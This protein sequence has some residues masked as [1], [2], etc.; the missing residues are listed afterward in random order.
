MKINR[1]NIEELLIEVFI[2]CGCQREEATIVAHNLV[3][4]EMCGVASHGLR[5]V[6]AHADKYRSSVYQYAKPL[7]IEV[8]TNAFAKINANGMCGLYSATRCMEFAI[9]KA[10]QCGMYTVFANHCNTYG[11]A[12]VYSLMAA[13]QGLIGITFCNTPAQMAPI[14][15]ARKMLGTNPMSYAIPVKGE[16]PIIYD[17]ATSIVAKSKINVAAERGDEIPIEWALDENGVPTTNAKEAQKGSVRPMAGPKG[18]GLAMLFDILSGVLSGAKY[19]DQVGRFYGSNTS[20][21]LGQTFIAINPSM[22]YGD[23]F[24]ETMREYVKYLR[25][26]GTSS[27]VSLPGDGKWS[28]LSDALQDG[29]EIELSMYEELKQE[30]YERTNNGEQAKDLQTQSLRGGGDIFLRAAYLKAA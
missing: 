18:M 6:S 24:A 12:F 9:D 26:S 13:E 5:M 22:I 16:N 15:G 20:M 28:A 1:E 7:E 21:D 3:L 19:L 14:G 30:Q 29:I 4:T 10:K 8:E 25:K 27:Q 23:G 11:A 2:H 17:A